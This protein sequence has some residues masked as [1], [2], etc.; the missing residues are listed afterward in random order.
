MTDKPDT[1]SMTGAEF[2]RYVGTDPAKWAEAFVAA[3]D[4]RRQWGHVD[5]VAFVQGW[6][7]DYAEV[8]RSEAALGRLVPRQE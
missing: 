8:V 5:R 3:Y 1:T 2:R 6:L 4:H 7:R